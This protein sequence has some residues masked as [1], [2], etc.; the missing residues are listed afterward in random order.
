MPTLPFRW[1]PF[2][3]ARL[4]L[5]R[6]SRRRYSGGSTTAHTRLKRA[7]ML[8]WNKAGIKKKIYPRL[9][10]RASHFFASSRSDLPREPQD[11]PQLS[12]GGNGREK[13]QKDSA[14]VLLSARI[15]ARRDDFSECGRPGRGKLRPKRDSG[16]YRNPS[17]V[18]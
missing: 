18:P 7:L 8:T 6:E 16:S 15:F 1:R 3:R 12:R 2:V 13:A 9:E 11:A 17:Q 4:V 5:S 10:G 14:S